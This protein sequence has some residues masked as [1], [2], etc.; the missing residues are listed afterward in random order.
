MAELLPNVGSVVDRKKVKAVLDAR[1][2]LK[3]AERELSRDVLDKLALRAGSLVRDPDTGAIYEVE[4]GSA[5]TYS[6]GQPYL[7]LTLRRVYRSGRSRAMS[8]THRTSTGLER[9]EGE[10]NDRLN[11][12]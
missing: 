8:P 2:R 10:L 4:W 3:E 11:R 7:M 9:Y 1:D 12:P 5:S 6:H